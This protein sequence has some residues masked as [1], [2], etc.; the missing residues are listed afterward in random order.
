MTE[1]GN[2][3]WMKL[4]NVTSERKRWWVYMFLSC[5]TDPTFFHMHNKFQLYSLPW[6]NHIPNIL[7]SILRLLLSFTVFFHHNQFPDA[8]FA[9]LHRQAKAAKSKMFRTFIFCVF[10]V[11]NSQLQ[12]HWLHAWETRR[13]A[14]PNDTRNTASIWYFFMISTVH[15]RSYHLFIIKMPQYIS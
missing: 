8:N 7:I 13:K 9:L 14:I 4:K 6:Q 12:Q 10:M 11:W 1:Q 5:G 2:I 3:K 15:F